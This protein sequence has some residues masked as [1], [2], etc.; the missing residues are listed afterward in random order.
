M[1]TETQKVLLDG[2][3]DLRRHFDVVAE[4]LRGDIRLLTEGLETYRTESKAG[5]AELRTE[6]KGDIQVVADG[7]TSTRTTLQGEIAELRTEL[8]GEIREQRSEMREEFIELRS[9][10]KLSYAE[11][12]RRFRTLEDMVF[13]LQNRVERLER[14]S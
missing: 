10:V 14:A 12:D 6:L 7:L 8:R 4:D 13:G 1:D 3:A 5:L 2:M 9:M 11:I